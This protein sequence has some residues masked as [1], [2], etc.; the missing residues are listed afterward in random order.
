MMLRYLSHASFPPEVH[1]IGSRTM[2]LAPR[3]RIMVT[4]GKTSRGFVGQQSMSEESR[5]DGKA[6]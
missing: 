2:G 5:S 6:I 1:S 4:I 3:A